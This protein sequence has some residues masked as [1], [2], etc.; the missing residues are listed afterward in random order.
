VRWLETPAGRVPV[1]SAALTRADRVGAWKA[2]W[3]IGRMSYLVP[4][5]LYAV[6]SPTPRD[7]VLVT[8]NYKMSYDLVRREL[9]GRSVWILVLETF[10]INVWCAA[11]KG[12]F[13]G[14]ELAGRIASSRLAAVVAHRVLV[15]PLLGAPGISAHEVRERT[16]FEVRFATVRA[17]DIPRYLDAGLEAAPGMRELTFTA[18]ERLVLIPIEL[19]LALQGSLWILPLLFLAGAWRGG[20]FTPAASLP[21]IAAYLGAVAAGTIVTPAL[22]PWL[23]TRSFAVKGAAVGLAWALLVVSAT[24]WRGTAAAAAVLLTGAVSSFLALNFTGA[25]PFTSRSGVKKEMRL[26]M[27]LMA[28]SLAAGLVLWAVALFA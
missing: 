1:V 20:A 28:A 19:V 27:P 18:R 10:G 4:P 13:G 24:G 2:R 21:V 15:L 7:P 22:L 11:G 3:G 9:A 25:T 23:P 26:S 5:G 17:E 16:G 6:G 14:E 12:T 8:A